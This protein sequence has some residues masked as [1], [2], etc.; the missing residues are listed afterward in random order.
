MDAET[1][2]IL[3]TIVVQEDGTVALPRSF[4]EELRQSQAQIELQPGRQEL[5]PPLQPPSWFQQSSTSTQHLGLQNLMPNG[6]FH[7]C[8]FNFK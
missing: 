4:G 1:D 5:T 7:G 2:E 3:A 8:T 6:V